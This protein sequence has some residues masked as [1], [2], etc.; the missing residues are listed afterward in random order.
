MD[1]EQLYTVKEI[2]DIA[3]VSRQ[4]LIYYDSIGL[5]KPEYVGSNGYRKYSTHQIMELREILFMKNNGIPLEQIKNYLLDH[6]AEQ[7][8]QGLKE[9]QESLLKEAER[10]MKC[11]GRLKN[12]MHALDRAAVEQYT[13]SV[14]LIKYFP[15]RI[16]FWV[17]WPEGLTREKNVLYQSFM[18]ARRCIEALGLEE[19]LG[20]GGII[21]TAELYSA[22]W[23]KS[24]GSYVYLPNEAD[25]SFERYGSNVE[26]LPAGEYLCMNIFGMPYEREPIDRLFSWAKN[27]DVT[28]EGDLIVECLLD[29]SYP[30]ALQNNA[31]FS[32]LQVRISR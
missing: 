15:E 8:K 14:P 2:A 7:L 10:L 11:A 32:Q 9:A 30:A 16:I 13:I 12:R 24:G 19:D 6:D 27:Q 21:R 28:V 25:I 23:L 5:F 20:W 26:Y 29:M 22:D 4:T 17:P 3:G 18:E 31:D 1:Q